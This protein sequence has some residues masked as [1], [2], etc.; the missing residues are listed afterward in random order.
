MV[1]FN[2][3]G[4]VVPFVYCMIKSLYNETIYHNIMYINNYIIIET[5]NN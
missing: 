4:P 2:G 5:S 1:E 3:P